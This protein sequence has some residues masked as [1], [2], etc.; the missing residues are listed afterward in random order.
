EKDKSIAK[1]SM[2][3]GYSDHSYFCRVFKKIRGVSPSSYR[4]Q[5]FST[6]KREE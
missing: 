4:R 1:I 5:Y 6:R 2:L 3:V